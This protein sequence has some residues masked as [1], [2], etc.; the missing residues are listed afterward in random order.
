MPALRSALKNKDPEI[1]TRARALIHKIEGNLLTKETSVRLDFNDATPDEIARSLS[2]Q[3]GFS[4]ALGNPGPNPGNKRV[5]IRESKPLPFW[6]AIDRLCEEA[7]LTPEFQN[8]VMPGQTIPQ[9]GLIFSYQAEPLNP[10][11]YDHGPFRVSVSGLSYQSQVS[12]GHSARLRSQ[13]R[14]AGAGI[15]VNQGRA[16]A[17]WTGRTAPGGSAKSSESDG[18]GNAP[19]RTVHFTVSL[20]IVPEPRMVL[21]SVGPLQLLEAAD[22][23]GNSLLPGSKRDDLAPVP[24]GM[25]LAAAGRF[26]TTASAALH[27]PETAGKVIKTLRGTVEVWVSRSRADPLVIPLEGAAGKT[28]QNDDLHVVVN[29]IDTDPMTRQNLIELSIEDLDELFP[30][31]PGN[32]MG[33]A[34]RGGMMAG[35]GN[36]RFGGDARSPIQVIDSRGQN[37]FFQSTIDR[38]S[39]RVTL[40][41]PNLPQVGAIKEVRLSSIIRAKAKIPFEFTD[42]P[43]P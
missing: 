19:A 7:H 15:E 17:Q 41:M 16:F 11:K 10:P 34:A 21:T 24:V 30:D 23:L 29:S 3:A 38:D 32:G 43:M 13:I 18:A 22:D 9:R 12:Y 35:M 2:K 33:F 36:P 6:K 39:G 28:F 25:G 5:T 40:R 27:R 8:S 14:G 31:E 37:V 4:I 1:R 42:L 20:Q 26:A